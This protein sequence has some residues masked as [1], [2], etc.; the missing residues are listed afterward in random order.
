MAPSLSRGAAAGRYVR[1]VSGE[2]LLSIAGG[3][4]ALALSADFWT[5]AVVTETRTLALA[6]DTLILVLLVVPR[7]HAAPPLPDPGRRA[8]HPGS[9]SARR[10]QCAGRHVLLAAVLYGLALSDHLLSLYLAPALIVLAW[11]ATGVRRLAFGARPNAEVAGQTAGPA[12][13]GPATAVAG[14]TT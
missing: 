1:R 5:E 6:L 7:P 10:A 9:G 2:G 12:V 4:V 3:M 13:P 8:Q 14:Q 11:P